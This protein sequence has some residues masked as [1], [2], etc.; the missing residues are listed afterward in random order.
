MGNQTERTDLTKMISGLVG[1]FPIESIYVNRCQNKT[2]KRE[3]IILIKYSYSKKRAARI[4]QIEEAFNILP[5]VRAH[6]FTTRMARAKIRNGNLF[7]FNSCQPHKLL[8]RDAKSAYSPIV[9]EFDLS[10]CLQHAIS[11]DRRENKKIQGFEDAYYHFK[12]NRSFGLAAFMLHQTIE[13]TYRYLSILLTAKER[14]T[15]SIRHY[16]RHTMNICPIY[17]S[18]FD[19]TQATDLILLRFLE[20]AYRESRYEDEFNVDLGMLDQLEA[21]MVRLRQHAQ[22]IFIYTLRHYE[23]GDYSGQDAP[24]CAAVLRD[25]GSS[26]QEPLRLVC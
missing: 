12:A 8:Y 18:I 2:E 23:N 3:L 25:A 7:L 9:E 21:K 14:I 13:L 26:Y 1:S 11:F 4:R 17:N 15:H 20:K 10:R 22:Y 6:C 5:A 19:E 24:A 16:H